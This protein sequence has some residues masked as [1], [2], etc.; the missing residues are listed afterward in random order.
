LTKQLGEPLL[1]ELPATLWIAGIAARFSQHG[2][3]CLGHTLLQRRREHYQTTFRADSNRSVW[4]FKVEKPMLHV[5]H[6]AST[7]RHDLNWQNESL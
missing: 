3:K 4:R 1:G 7:E 2:V 6:K 5:W